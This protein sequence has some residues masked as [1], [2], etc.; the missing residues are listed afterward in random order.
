MEFDFNF[1]SD[2]E[3]VRREE[4]PFSVL[5]LSDF[6]AS[7]RPLNER[8]PVRV[9][10]DNL[11]SLWDRFRPTIDVTLGDRSISVAPGSLEDLH[12]D[13]LFRQLEPF[14]QLRAF[15]AA[16]RDPEHG[17]A[18]LE[19]LRHL[20]PDVLGDSG[21]PQDSAPPANDAP[22]THESEGDLLGRLLGRAPEPSAGS[23]KSVEGG[24]DALLRSAVA[25]HIVHTPDPRI[26]DAIA[27]VDAAL[28]DLMRALLHDPGFRALE[29]RWRS[30]YRLV[31]EVELDEQVQLWVV[32]ASRSELLA[33][34]PASF[35]QLGACGLHDLLLRRFPELTE[36]IPPSVIAVDAVFSD[37]PDDLALL[38][39][40]GALADAAGSSVLAAGSPQLL[41]AADVEALGDHRRWA[42]E[43]TLPQSW[44]TLRAA[45]FAQRIGLVLPDVLARLPYG[46]R[47]EPVAPFDFEEVQSPA[48]DT[49][50]WANAV[51][52]VCEG[53]MRRFIDDR[54]SMN[55]G[56]A[57]EIEALPAFSYRDAGET[58]LLP[59]TRQLMPESSIEVALRR[60]LSPVAGFRNQDRALVP[61]LQSIAEPLAPLRG[62]WSG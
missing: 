5:L 21:G 26:D 56:P 58:R 29:A 14:G 3:G 50:L 37:H 39:T 8:Q 45:P 11:N 10:V 34:L 22:S 52:V 31:Q 57:M 27:G 24:L 42:D 59:C 53:L 1:R 44:Q 16:L 55:P 12:P 36:G 43:G 60:G 20:E 38:A 32:S 35:E 18:M 6:G 9:D 2:S 61:R 48:A 28:S 4:R 40:L 41:G 17:S 49:F 33:G 47:T 46:Q 62:P 15:R 7:A 19:Q 13:Q 25:P 30:L 51:T 54:W 23:S